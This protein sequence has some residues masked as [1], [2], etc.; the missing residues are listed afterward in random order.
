MRSRT[1]HLHMSH[2]SPRQAE[3]LRL[4]EQHPGIT[5]EQLAHAHGVG[6]TRTWQIVGRLSGPRVLVERYE[7]R[8]RR[9]S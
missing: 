7:R 6:I 2:L 3:A 4:I 5:V 9:R 8:A 1:D